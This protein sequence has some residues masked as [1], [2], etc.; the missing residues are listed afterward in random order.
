MYS[1]GTWYSMR[2]AARAAPCARARTARR[3]RCARGSAKCARYS[4]HCSVFSAGRL[5]R[6][7]DLRLRLGGREQRVATSAAIEAVARATCVDERWISGRVR[8]KCA[9]AM[10]GAAGA[11]RA[12]A[13]HDAAA[14]AAAPQ[15][16]ACAAF[17]HE[18]T[19]LRCEYSAI[20]IP[21]PASS[22]TTERAAVADQ[23]QRHA[24]HRQQ[25]ADHA[26]VDEHVDEE[27][28]REA[29]GEQAREGVLVCVAS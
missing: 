4:H 13:A 12:A 1:G 14:A 29:A 5:M 11:A 27:G 9:R 10:R 17:T 26:G 6:V 3:R 15:Q 23:R 19:S 18:P 20:R 25:A 28:Q 16:R 24:D 8:S 7:D 2:D 22:V 21:K